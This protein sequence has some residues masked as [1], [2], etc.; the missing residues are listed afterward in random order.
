MKKYYV[1]I[2]WLL[3]GIEQVNV[4][5]VHASTEVSAL[6]I[7]RTKLRAI[8]QQVDERYQTVREEVS[9]TLPPT[10]LAEHA[11]LVAVADKAAQ[12]LRRME[13]DDDHSESVMTFNN[14][15]CFPS[16]LRGAIADLAAVRANNL[17]AG[18]K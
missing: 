10:P 4:L 9:E 14:V 16:E 11:A 1:T 2:H 3:A 15:S 6:N 17:P 8:A 13:M 7:A 18:L 12:L 5:P